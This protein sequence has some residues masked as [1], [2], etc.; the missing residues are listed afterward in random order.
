MS[1]VVQN[2]IIGNDFLF[3]N[4][5]DLLYGTKTLCTRYG[6]TP[7]RIQCKDSRTVVNTV[8]LTEDI[9]IK[10]RHAAVTEG[11]V[12]FSS[13]ETVDTT[14]SNAVLANEDNG[15][16]KEI[17][18]ALSQA[19][20]V[21]CGHTVIFQKDGRLTKNQMVEK[22][23]PKQC[24]KRIRLKSNSL[25]SS[26]HLT[27]ERR[28][29]SKR[30]QKTVVRKYFVRYVFSLCILLFILIE[31]ANLQEAKGTDAIVLHQFGAVLEKCGRVGVMENLF[32]I[33]MVLRLEMPPLHKTWVNCTKTYNIEKLEA[34][35]RREAVHPTW[36]GVATHANSSLARNKR[37]ILEVV[38]LVSGLVG[39]AASIYT[40]IEV[41]Q[42]KDQQKALEDHINSITTA[43]T[44]Q[45]ESIVKIEK[46]MASL[47][48]YTHSEF[49]KIATQLA[50]LECKWDGYA[51]FTFLLMEKIQMYGKLYSDFDA[52]TASLFA[53]RLSPI[54]LPVRNLLALTSENRIFKNTIYEDRPLVLYDLANVYPQFPLR[55]G[56]IA[57]ILAV[58]II[59]KP[60]LIPMYCVNNLGLV[61]NNLVIKYPLS[62]KVV[63]VNNTY[64]DMNLAGCTQH[65]YEVYVCYLNGRF[66]ESNCLGKNASC[67]PKI[68][69]FEKI[70]WKSG[71]F[72]HLVLTNSSCQRVNHSSKAQTVTNVNGSVFIPYNENGSV[73]CNPDVV[74]PMTIRSFE[75][76]LY[77]YD[78]FSTIVLEKVHSYVTGDWQD[79]ASLLELINKDSAPFTLSTI[80]SLVNSTV[81]YWVLGILAICVALALCV[82]CVCCR[83]QM[84]RK[85]LRKKREKRLC[86]REQI[87]TIETKEQSDEEE[88]PPGYWQNIAQPNPETPNA[89]AVEEYIHKHVYPQ[90]EMEI[91]PSRSVDS[92]RMSGLDF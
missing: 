72:G 67:P 6:C 40:T 25:M 59:T 61:R 76:S 77:Y 9:V 63:I 20:T 41:N 55:Q 57:Y 5:C 60:W 42:L 3:V 11:K 39:L 75:Y 14:E 19:T 16:T 87:A 47:Y 32:H 88:K 36:Q 27:G 84:V 83:Q 81:V 21:L 8:Y 65:D 24:L 79:A 31:P 45:H 43:V 54:L 53:H 23:L 35:L 33:G 2:C 28:C 58:P 37:Q 78:N 44:E 73:F 62:E 18:K 4:N 85:Q 22:R 69:K 92:P 29:G 68:K 38:G 89:P 7:L 66:R 80:H 82:I 12:E 86:N 70:E 64:M 56:V 52:A 34:Q 26:E 90:L 13:V 48:E 91:R 30:N 17:Q 71:T 51:S 49:R 46:S 74:L 50:E 10:P 15:N 1:D